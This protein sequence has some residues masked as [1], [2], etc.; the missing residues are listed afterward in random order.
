VDELWLAD[1]DAAVSVCTRPSWRGVPRRLRVKILRGYYRAWMHTPT[2]LQW[3]PRETETG[4]L[5]G[6]L[7]GSGDPGYPLPVD[8]ATQ[9]PSTGR[10]A[11]RQASV[12]LPGG[13]GLSRSRGTSLS[14]GILRLSVR[15]RATTT[16]P[17]AARADA[18]PRDAYRVGEITH[19]MVDQPFQGHGIGRALVEEACR[20]A[21]L[22]GVDAWSGSRRP[23]GAPNGS[24]RGFGWTVPRRGEERQW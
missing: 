22:F 13:I 21:R 12:I 17:S 15:R 16:E 3:Q 7:L 1:I 24:T 14:P 8:G 6:L 19:L 2:A 20:R 5:I 23:V 18:G 10:S 4:Q 11:R 9:R